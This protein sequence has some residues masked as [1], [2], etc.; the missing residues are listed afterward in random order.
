MN[1]LSFDCFTQDFYFSK[2]YLPQAEENSCCEYATLVLVIK[3]TLKNDDL[4]ETKQNFE[5][6]HFVH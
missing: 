5:V 3:R 6:L 2:K 4:F 1:L